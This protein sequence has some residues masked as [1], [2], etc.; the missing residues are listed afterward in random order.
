M[1]RT[2][3]ALNIQP[4]SPRP[5][6]ARHK[7]MTWIHQNKFLFFGLCLIALLEIFFGSNFGQLLF[8]LTVAVGAFWLWSRW[9][10]ASQGRWQYLARWGRRLILAGLLCWLGLFALVQ[11]RIHS[12]NQP[13]PIG[14]PGWLVVLGAGL[15]GEAPAPLLEQRLIRAVAILQKHPQ[16]RVVVSGGK[17]YDEAISEAEAMRRYLTAAGIANERILLENQSFSTSDNIV[18]SHR[19]LASQHGGSAPA[20]WILS[21]E[22]H[23]YRASKQA[24]KLGWQHGMQAAPT[25]WQLLLICDLRESVTV[26]RDWLLGRYGW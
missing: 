22:F 6:F 7:T 8:V 9:V 2:T 18:F 5:K 20:V 24:A 1:T 19:L 4:R 14:T 16:M 26:G 3:Q 25:P 11:Y 15:S 13:A 10:L 17:G 12:W 23:L 21:S